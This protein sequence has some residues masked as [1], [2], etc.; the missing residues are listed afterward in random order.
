MKVLGALTPKRHGE[1]PVSHGVVKQGHIILLNF[2]HFTLFCI[3][4]RAVVDEYII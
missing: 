4:A 2:V 3:H 1:N